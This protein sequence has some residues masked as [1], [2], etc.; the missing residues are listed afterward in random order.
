MIKNLKF[1]LIDF[2]GNSYI[3]EVDKLKEVYFS[4]PSFS[5]HNFKNNKK[6]KILNKKPIPFK[7]YQNAFE[8]IIE[9]I[10]KGNTYLLNLTFPTK[11]ETNCD[12]LEIFS[13]SN[14]QFK[15]YFKNKFVCFS[16]ERFVKIQ[17]NKISTYPMKG[18]IDASIPNA[19]EKILS[20][21]KEMAEHTMVVD[22]LRNDLGIIGYNVK[23][24]KFRFIDKIKAGDKELLQVS[25]EIEATLPNNWHYNWL[26]LIKQM[27]PAGSITGTPKK[28]TVEIIKKAENYERGFYTGIFGITDEKT[29]LDSAVIIRYIENP[30]NTPSQLHHLSTSQVYNYIYKSGGGITIDSNIKDEYDEL[31]KKV[32][33]PN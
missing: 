32:Y 18:T 23:V 30:N 9:E 26:E 16:P 10:K 13:S 24:N 19:K 1:F 4:F 15:L 27:L 20:N 22:L 7:R 29:F 17:N 33:I 3:E 12:L 31:I 21:I 8:F 11:I 14:A 6:C 5:N 28:K 25:S 2:D